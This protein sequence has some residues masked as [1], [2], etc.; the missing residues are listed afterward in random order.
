M[1]FGFVLLKW[2]LCCLTV[3]RGVS[4]VEQDL[5]TLPGHIIFFPLYI[6]Q[7]SQRIVQEKLEDAIW[8]IRNRK[9]K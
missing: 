1:R 4:Q 6:Y 7:L 9:Q 3:T 8:E 2:C 5:L